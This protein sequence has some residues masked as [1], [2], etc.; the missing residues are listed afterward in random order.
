MAYDQ[1]LTVVLSTRMNCIPP[2]PR[3]FIDFRQF[4]PLTVIPLNQ[5][6]STAANFTRHQIMLTE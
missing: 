4:S 3:Q 5:G 1:I 6:N 2:V